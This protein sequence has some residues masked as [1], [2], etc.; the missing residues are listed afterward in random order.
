MCPIVERED[1][2]RLLS[3]GKCVSCQNG[4]QPSADKSQCLPCKQLP[5]LTP[6]DLT[7]GHGCN[8]RCQ[9]IGYLKF[10]QLCKIRGVFKMMPLFTHCLHPPFNSMFV[11]HTP[12]KSCINYKCYYTDP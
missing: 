6:G 7:D 9:L 10:V 8:C 5:M 3:E 11:P 4:T 12:S 2:G 1:D